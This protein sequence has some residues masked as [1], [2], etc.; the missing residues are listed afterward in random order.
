ML[1]FL[2]A[3]KVLLNI[4]FERKMG[5]TASPLCHKPYDNHSLDD[6]SQVLATSEQDHFYNWALSK[7][8]NNR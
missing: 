2:P 7:W 8:V 6:G 4:H 5:N 3:A 1:V